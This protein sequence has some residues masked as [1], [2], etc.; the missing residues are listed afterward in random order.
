MKTSVILGAGFSYVA[1]LPLA[2]DLFDSATFIFSKAAEKRHNEVWNVFDQWRKDNPNFGPEQF[3]QS[4][5]ENPLQSRI[6]WGWAVELVGATLA[7]PR[8]NDIPVVRNR[9]YAG[10]LTKPLNNIDHEQFWNIIFRHGNVTSVLTFN[11]DLLAEREIRHRQFV[12]KPRPGFYYGGF[13]RP[14]ICIGNQAP[15]SVQKPERKVELTGLIPL[16]KLHGSLNW[17]KNQHKIEMYTDMR[18]AFRSG[19]DALI[20]PPA[21][22]KKVPGWLH[23]VWAGS[24]NALV[25][26]DRWIVCGYSLPPYDY[27]ARELFERAAREGTVKQVIILDPNSKSLKKIWRA[28]CPN[29]IIKTLSGI[30]DGLLSLQ[31]ILNK[32]E[33]H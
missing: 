10:Q 18:P 15:F 27:V 30:P 31:V 32:S 11:Y 13:P 8:G 12:K 4:V 28:I 21:P 17:A 9:R 19:G 16:Y 6:P 5:Y 23:S 20:V 25:H 22:E 2:K 1:G 14:Q 24:E 33:A 26:S 7:S 29:A 3:L